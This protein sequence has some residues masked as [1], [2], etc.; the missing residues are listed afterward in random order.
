MLSVFT[1]RRSRKCG[2]VFLIEGA[3]VIVMNVFELPPLADRSRIIDHQLLTRWVYGTGDDAVAADLVRKHI[4]QRGMRWRLAVQHVRHTVLGLSRFVARAGSCR[5]AGVDTM[6]RSRHRSWWLD[7]SRASH[8]RLSTEN[9]A[10]AWTA[11]PS[12]RCH[13]APPALSAMPSSIDGV[14]F[15]VAHIGV[16]GEVLLPCEPAGSSSLPA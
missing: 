4:R 10:L 15:L 7:H 5:E 1:I 13:R 16:R 8:C 3:S 2:L 14:G 6:P 12:K 9:A 11:L